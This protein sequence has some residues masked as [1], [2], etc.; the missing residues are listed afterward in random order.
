MLALLRWLLLLFVMSL[1]SVVVLVS[2]VSLSRV[3]FHRL[4]CRGSCP[5]GKKYIVRREVK[6]SVIRDRYC[7]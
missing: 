7:Y 3:A 6:D 5:K 2:V 4:F 1:C